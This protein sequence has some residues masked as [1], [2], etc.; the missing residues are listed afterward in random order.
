MIG[1]DTCYLA[2]GSLDR[3]IIIWNIL[4]GNKEMILSG[5]ESQI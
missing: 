4:T 2:S 5:S 3:K 1:I